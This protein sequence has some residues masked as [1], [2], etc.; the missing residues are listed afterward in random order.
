M[1]LAGHSFQFEPRGSVEL[2]GHG[3]MDTYLV[4]EPIP[5]L[6]QPTSVASSA[7]TPPS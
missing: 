7:W 6:A 1:E 2:R 5:S 3:A 4:I